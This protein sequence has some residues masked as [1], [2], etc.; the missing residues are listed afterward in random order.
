MRV[1]KIQA[2]YLKMAI[3]DYLPDASV[4]LIGS[5]AN[6]KLRG[7]DIDILVI[8]EKELTGQEKRNIKLSFYKE[9]GEQKIDIVSFK[10]DE[11]SNFKELALLESVKL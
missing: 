3:K 4:Y 1:K 10:R 7:G 8:G 11:P 9:F 6:D 2:E 5:R